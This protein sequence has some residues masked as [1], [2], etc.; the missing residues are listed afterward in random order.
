MLQSSKSAVLIAAAVAAATTAYAEPSAA[1][2]AWFEQVAGLNRPAL[3]EPAGSHGTAGLAIGG[4][5]SQHQAPTPSEIARAE[6]AGDDGEV[7]SLPRIWLVKGLPLPVDLLFS[8]GEGPDQRFTQATA[9]VQW[10]AIEGLGVPTLAVRASG[11]GLFGCEAT[12][13]RTEGLEL[14]ASYSML[15]YLTVFGSAGYFQHTVQLHVRE[16]GSTAFL[17]EQGGTGQDY[18]K[19]W[20]ERGYAAGVRVVALPPFVAVTAEAVYS[21]GAPRGGALKLSVGI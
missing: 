11:G 9:A 10:N 8:G 1:V 17:L 15:R 4:G 18:R 5:I 12:E 13:A 3:A 14:A 20:R 6:L 16:E 2:D 19:S 7:L 21:E